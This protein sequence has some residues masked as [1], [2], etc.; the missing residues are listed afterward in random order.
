MSRG[1]RPRRLSRSCVNWPKQPGEGARRGS[2]CRPTKPSDILHSCEHLPGNVKRVHTSVNA[3]RKS[4]YA[5]IARRLTDGCLPDGR[6]VL[7]LDKLP[8][9]QHNKLIFVRI[10]ALLL[11]GGIGSCRNCHLSCC[12]RSWS[13]S[14]PYTPRRP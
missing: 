3:A 10:G 4:A 7:H 5:T 14:L 12:W 9:I 6:S 13:R 8:P 1:R 2:V 11:P